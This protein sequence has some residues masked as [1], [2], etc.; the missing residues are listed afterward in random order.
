MGARPTV[1]SRS[2]LA[3]QYRFPSESGRKAN[4]RIGQFSARP[5]EEI[6]PGGAPKGGSSEP[7]VFVA[8]IRAPGRHGARR[9]RRFG[10]QLGRGP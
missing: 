6:R 4:P 7:T 10:C 1:Q 5:Q 2:E 3:I 9:I 8:I